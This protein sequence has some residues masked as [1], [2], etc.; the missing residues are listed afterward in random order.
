M[1]LALW[2]P[3][4]ALFVVLTFPSPTAYARAAKTLSRL[5][6]AFHSVVSRW[7]NIVFLPTL[8]LDVWQFRRHGGGFWLHDEVDG[9][10]VRSK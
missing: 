5:V 9:E 4:L 7:P 3:V 8:V 6:T 10:F 1:K 2:M